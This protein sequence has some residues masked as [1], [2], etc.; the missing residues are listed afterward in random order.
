MIE[1]ARERLGERPNLELRVADLCELDLGD[2]RADAILSTATFHWIKDHAPLFARL[3]GGAARRRR[4]SSRSAAARATSASC[5]RPARRS[6][7]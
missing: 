6:A 4:G 7:R 5:A 1:A 3:R 2:E